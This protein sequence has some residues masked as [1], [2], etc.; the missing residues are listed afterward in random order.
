LLHSAWQPHNT[1]SSLEGRLLIQNTRFEAPAR[2][3]FKPISYEWLSRWW[4]K[5][6]QSCAMRF[7]LTSH[8]HHFQPFVSCINHKPFHSEQT[9]FMRTKGCKE[10]GSSRS[11][12]L[13]GMVC[14]GTGTALNIRSFHA[15]ARPRLILSTTFSALGVGVSHSPKQICGL[16]GQGPQKSL[17]ILKHHTRSSDIAF[18]ILPESA[19]KPLVRSSLSPDQKLI[20]SQS[21]IPSAAKT[22]SKRTTFSRKPTKLLPVSANTS[23][24]YTLNAK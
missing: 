4:C 6:D 19:I 14:S 2:Q 9:N 13:S 10:V 11:S 20:F 18:T 1:T 22:S 16:I 8:D 17:N 5:I 15:D 24:S 7:A 23:T 3:E 12:L 21:P